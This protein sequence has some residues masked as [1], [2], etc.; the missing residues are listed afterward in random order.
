MEPL[1]DGEPVLGQLDGRR[2]HLGEA[3]PAVTG[4]GRSPR[5]HDRGNAG[6]QVAVSGYQVDAV[7]AAPVDGELAGRP[8]HAADGHRLP[9]PGGVDQC[10][11]LAADAVAL[12]LQQVHAEAHGRRGVDGVS[13]LL[14]DPEARRRGQVVARGNDPPGPHD[15]RPGCE[16]SHGILLV[17]GWAAPRRAHHIRRSPLMRYNLD[18]SKAID[19]KEVYRCICWRY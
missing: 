2:Q 1:V 4:D 17:R 9:L 10:G 12:G 7:G 18:E 6:G 11:R 19:C 15:D 3:Q 8:A 14:H 16:Y 5:V 13:A